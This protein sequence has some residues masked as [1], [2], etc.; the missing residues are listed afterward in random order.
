MR[1]GSLAVPVQEVVTVAVDSSELELA[2]QVQLLLFPK[3]SPVCTWCCI[4]MKNR[5][6]GML[7]GDYY[8][9]IEM[10][11]GCQTLFVGDVTGHGLHASVVMSLIYGFIHHA[12]LGSC[13][14]YT[15]VHEVNTFLLHFSQRSRI[16]D[17]YFSSTLFF[18]IINPASLQMIYVNAGH[19]P[20]LVR[21]GEEIIEL[22]PTSQ[23]V[24]FF[25]T[26]DI[27]VMSFQFQK[28]D[29]LLLYTDGI[30]EAANPVGELFGMARLKQ[31]LMT[32]DSDHLLFLETLFDSLARFG[33]PEPPE[34]DCTALL[35]D[36]HGPLGTVPAGGSEL[37]PDPGSGVV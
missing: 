19:P 24:G 21:R 37:E 33:I 9:F 36:I 11:D 31:E 2:R 5:I 32:D 22:C 17:Q 20:P 14:P 26:L 29:R 6:D 1:V 8:D 3:S 35:I 25:D 16:V 15:V 30:T 13:D 34:D 12:A 7:G 10:P 4:G 27:E 28:G 23:P 18:G